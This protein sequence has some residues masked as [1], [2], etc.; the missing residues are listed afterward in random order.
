MHQKSNYT[1]DPIPFLLLKYSLSSPPDSISFMLPLFSG[2][3]CNIH[4]II[5]CIF[6]E[7]FVQ[8]GKYTGS[9]TIFT[10]SVLFQMGNGTLP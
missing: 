5:H 7:T 2:S 1:S 6:S 9:F 8:L 3:F 4:F 10:I